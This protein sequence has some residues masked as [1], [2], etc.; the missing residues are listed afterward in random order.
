MAM[1]ELTTGFEPGPAQRS[2][3]SSFSKLFSK[4]FHVGAVIVA[5]LVEWLLSNPEVRGSNRVIG[6]NLYWTLFTVNYIEKTNENKEKE[7]GNGPFEKK[8]LRRIFPW[9]AVGSCF[10]TASAGGENCSNYDD[11]Q[12]SHRGMEKG[13]VWLKYREFGENE[14]VYLDR[15]D[16]RK[17]DCLYLGEYSFTTDKYDMIIEI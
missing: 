11:Y 6:K 15:C 12:T 9:C 4:S 8:F 14:I 16:N 2:T 13:R 3:K 10:V 17:K 7:A 1:G 5:Q